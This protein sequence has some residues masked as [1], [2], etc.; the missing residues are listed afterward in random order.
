M[1]AIKEFAVVSHVD[2]RALVVDCDV[3]AADTVA[4]NLQLCGYQA[5]FLLPV[6][7]TSLREALGWVP[8]L[9]VV[10]VDQLAGTQVAEVVTM[11]L[12]RKVAV[13]V[14]TRDPATV[15]G[16][17]GVVVAEKAA[18]TAGPES[19]RRVV[20]PE[21]RQPTPAAPTPSSPVRGRVVEVA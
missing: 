9:A 10:D 2:R 20:D 1:S 19:V 15:L 8:D 7:T 4:A 11:L 13:V 12:E 14:V 6:S 5:R 17:P 18:M 21:S 16:I 3:L